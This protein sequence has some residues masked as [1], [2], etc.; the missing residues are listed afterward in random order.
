M[1]KLLLPTDVEVTDESAIEQN[2]PKASPSRVCSD[3]E[4]VKQV[5]K[6]TEISLT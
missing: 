2:K 4:E 6:A 1:Q 5:G 3:G